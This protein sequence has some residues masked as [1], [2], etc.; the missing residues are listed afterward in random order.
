MLLAPRSLALDHW[1]QALAH[2]GADCDL[3]RFVDHIQS[4]Q[5]PHAVL[6]DCTASRA[7]AER[8]ADWLARGIHVITPNKKA[9]SGSWS[10]YEKL[11]QQRRANRVHYLYETTVGAG[12][13]ILQTL[14]DLRETGD[15]IHSVE[16]ILSGTLAYLFN[17][18]DGRRPFSEI[19]REARAKGYTEPDPRD[20]LT[21]ADVAN[22]VIILARERPA[23]RAR[24][25]ESRIARARRCSA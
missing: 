20:D 17:L 16:G 24:R 5:V 21:G 10:Y 2:S 13:P 15:V 6:I 12:L 4:D 3:D 7:V 22:K 1:E 18:F 9:N 25:R 8:Y 19:V 23:A 11:L 14:R